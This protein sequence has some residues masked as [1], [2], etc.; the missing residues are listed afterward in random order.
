MV[1]NITAAT[2]SASAATEAAVGAALASTTAA[3]AE[4]LT[5]ALP[6]GVDL[7]SLEFAAA[8]NAAGAAFI[9]A[10]SAHCADRQLFSGAQQFAAATYVATDVFNNAA[11][12]L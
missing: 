11:L 7:D 12:A 1:L 8:L 3:V 2:I 6:M 5:A 9:G 10:A 4:P